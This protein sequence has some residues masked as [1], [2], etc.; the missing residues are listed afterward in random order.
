MSSLTF[1]CR[2]AWLLGLFSGFTLLL[3]CSS[4]SASPVTGGG[5][6]RAE[7]TTPHDA[8]HDGGKRDAGEK[9]ASP[10]DS[11]T[12]S[13][14]SL[15]GWSVP[16]GCNPLAVTTECM[17]PYPSNLL[18]TADAGTVTG[19]RVALPPNSL[20]VPS[21][22]PAIDMAPFNR[23]D[24]FPTSSPILVHFGV[25]VSAQFLANDTQTASSISASSPIAVFNEAT[26]ER[27]A[28]L[29]E[30]D[31]NDPTD[32]SRHALIIRPLTPLDFNTQYVVALSSAL[33]DTSGNPLPVSKGF[34]A[35]RDK[36]STS[37]S[38]L[39]GARPHFES[40]FSFLAAHGF[41][42]DSLALA[43]DYTTASSEMVLGPITAMRQEVFHATTAKAPVPDGGAD[44][45]V[46]DAAIYD[47]GSDGGPGSITYTIT[48]VTSS[49]YQAGENIIE[50]T[51]T[52]PNY[53]ETDNT[54]S[55][56]S[57]GVPTLQT[58]RPAPSYPFTML[59]PPIAKTQSVALVLFGHGLFGAGREYLTTSFGS[60]IQ[61][62]AEQLGAVVVATDWIGLSSGDLQLIIDDVIPNVNRVGIVSDRLLQALTN[63]L[64]LI[65][66]SLG[67]LG[68]D[69]EVRLSSAQPL[70]DPS[71]VYYYGVSL[72]GIEGSS[73]ISVSRNVTRG[74][75]AVPGASWSNL[76][77]R[78]YDYQQIGS[79]L[80]LVYPDELLQQEFITLM[81]ARFDPADPANLATLFRRNPLPDSPS[82][83]T[84]II[85]E[86]I[87]DCQVPNLTTEI[88]ARAYGIN[89][90][91]PDIVPIYGL[92]D[93]TTPTTSIGLSQ[94][95]LSADVAKYI[96]PTTNVLPTM[97]NGAHFDL[98][99]RVEALAEVISLFN[100]GQIVQAC[101]D[102]GASSC[103]L[104]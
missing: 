94:F 42:R 66:L 56:S 1:A 84:V 11:G 82:S 19:L 71:R 67:A 37:N 14:A 51:F 50:G 96:P 7:A 5:D 43:W 91:T 59:V 61:P 86:S 95:E 102:A 38:L 72:G 65:E 41:A 13:D 48:S 85:Q 100:T 90:I 2:S 55:Y 98:A 74:V 92:T 49:M 10:P 29:S 25:D 73:L 4:G 79:A 31:A 27:I 24:G 97:D 64:S 20:T 32:P 75:V 68:D 8:G 83:R 18:I 15:D 101:G 80:A 57:A 76:L 60:T 28:F 81:Q 47:A 78:S 9:E 77:A 54:I 17:L 39:E 63:N 33:R 104:P 23:F 12:M 46:A 53:L 88:L 22:A 45:A 58:G 89:Q 16:A 62:L 70:L 103:I 36:I 3:G 35:L 40:I 6:A 26:G 34:V 87:D 99:F 21:T 93:I 69:P 30:M 44:A 52:P